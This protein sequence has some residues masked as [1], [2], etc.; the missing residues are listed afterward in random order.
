MA[1]LKEW[2][3]TKREANKVAKER[4]KKVFKQKVGRK[5]GKFFVGTEFDL[6]NRY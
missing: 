4:G 6:L 3:D 2:F 1:R 5:K